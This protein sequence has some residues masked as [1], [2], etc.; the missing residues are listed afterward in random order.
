MAAAAWW[1][2]DA[3]G[4]SLL[5]RGAVFALPRYPRFRFRPSQADA[6]QVDP[7]LGGINHLRDA[8]SYS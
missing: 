7:W 1:Q 3:G 5:R 2:L 8:G 6:L 4:Y